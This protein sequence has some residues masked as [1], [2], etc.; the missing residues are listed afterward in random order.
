MD[1]RLWR[2]AAV[3]GYAWMA[4]F[5][6]ALPLASIWMAADNRDAWRFTLWT[7]LDVLLLVTL[8][9]LPCATVLAGLH[10]VTRAR[11]RAVWHVVRAIGMG[12][13]LTALVGLAAMQSETTLEPFQAHMRWFA[14]AW[15]ILLLVPLL[16]R[17]GLRTLKTSAKIFAPLPLVLLAWFATVRQPDCRL[18]AVP[19]NLSTESAAVGG[20]VCF[21]MFDALDRPTVIENTGNLARFPN[22]RQCVNDYTWFPNSVSPHHKTR[23]TTPSVLFQRPELATLDDRG[24]WHFASGDTGLVLAD[25]PSLFEMLRQPGDVCFA[26]GTHVEYAEMLSGR[27]VSVREHAL[28]YPVH[29][30][31]GERMQVMTYHVSTYAY[32]P[33][34]RRLFGAKDGVVEMSQDLHESAIR[35]I[36][37]NRNGMIGFFHFLWPHPPFAYGPDGL[38]P[39]EQIA[40]RDEMTAYLSNMD[41]TDVKLGELLQALRDTGVYDQSTIV[42]FGDH[43]Y[44][45][46][47]Q[48]PLIV[49]LPGQTSGRV[50]EDK[51]GAHQIVRWLHAQPEFTRV[52]PPRN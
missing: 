3:F 52:R 19:E 5:A 26:C 8:V 1:S 47:N 45:Y 39:P 17:A 33:M 40:G 23:H 51:I 4:V 49:K 41:Y 12:L 38:L 25:L 22:L 28:W 11:G 35:A 27:D 44:P 50:V 37:Q 30:D 7:F 6:T 46:E 24:R 31:V 14:A 16:H 42:I 48:P 15:S 43:G 20:P 32:W 34:A 29:A 10:E 18:D 21:L 36:R 9:A 13:V 2:T